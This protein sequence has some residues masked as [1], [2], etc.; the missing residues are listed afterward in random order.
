[1]VGEVAEGPGHV[2]QGGHHAELAESRGQRAQ[3]HPED[4]RVAPLVEVQGRRWLRGAGWLIAGS[5]CSRAHPGTVPRVCPMV[6][7]AGGIE[8]PYGALQAPA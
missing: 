8:P 3:R 6:E 5:T 2:A 4:H 1:M 7:A